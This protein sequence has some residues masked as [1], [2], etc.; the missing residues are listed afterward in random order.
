MFRVG[1]FLDFVWLTTRTPH[2]AYVRAGT[3]T[4]P[5]RPPLA[6]GAHV[7]EPDEIELT[8]IGV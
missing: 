7:P 1:I 2:W 8:P 4:N 3:Q 5:N 6:H